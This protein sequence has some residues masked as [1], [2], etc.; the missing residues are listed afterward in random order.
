MRLEANRRSKGEFVVGC[1]EEMMLGIICVSVHWYAYIC[2]HC[3]RVSTAVANYN[4]MVLHMCAD[5]YNPNTRV[6]VPV[7]LGILPY[8]IWSQTQ[9]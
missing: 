8:S 6:L 7:T 4:S 9:G 1:Q 3:T 2:T 5:S